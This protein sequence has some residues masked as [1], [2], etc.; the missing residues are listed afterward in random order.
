MTAAKSVMK[1]RMGGIVR[2]VLW[3]HGFQV[4]APHW[5]SAPSLARARPAVGRPQPGDR[6]DP[7]Q[8][9]EGLQDCMWLR[10][11]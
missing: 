9:P 2:G 5:A 10:C 1:T 8:P 6:S 11:E 4:T 7:R 3:T